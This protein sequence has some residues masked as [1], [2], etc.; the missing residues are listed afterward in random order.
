VKI[1]RPEVGETIRCFG[2]KNWQNAKGAKSL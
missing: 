1:G 2:D